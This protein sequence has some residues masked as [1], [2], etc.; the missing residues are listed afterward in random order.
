[1]GAGEC[2]PDAFE[3]DLGNDVADDATAAEIREYELTLCPDDEDWFSADLSAG[4]RLVARATPAGAAENIRLTILGP[5]GG[6][7]ADGEVFGQTVAAAVDVAAPGRHLVRLW[8]PFDDYAGPVRLQVDVLAA[9]AA[10][11][12]ACGHAVPLEPNQE[13]AFSQTLPVPRFVVSCGDARATQHLASF[14]LAEPT[15]VSLRVTGGRALAVRSGCDDPASEQACSAGFDPALAGVELGV[16]LYYV[17]VGADAADSP[18]VLLTTGDAGC[19]ADAACG[20]GN[21]CVGGVCRPVCLDDASC[22]GVQLCDQGVC[23]EPCMAHAD[24]RA[25]GIC[26]LE[27]GRCLGGGV[28][29]PDALEAGLGNDDGDHATDAEIREYELT[30]CAG[31]EDWFAAE[32]SA[33]SRLAIRATP[34]RAADDVRVEILGPDGAVLVEGAVNG[35]SV[36]AET[37]VA[38]PGRHLVRLWSPLAD[39]SGA[40]RLQV[41]ARAADTAAALACSHPVPLEPDEEATFSPTLPVQRFQLSCG[42]FQATNHLASFELAEPTQVWLHVADGSALAVRSACAAAASEEAC[43]AG[44][45]PTLAGVELGAGTYYVVVGAAADA[46]PEVVLTLGAPGCVADVGCEAGEVCIDG[47]CRPACLDDA[48]CP[49]L[50]VCDAGRC[51]DWCLIDGDCGVGATCI[52]DTGHCQGGECLPDAFEGE[53]GNDSAD[54]ATVAEIREYPL[55][56]CAGDEDWFSAELSAGSRLVAR[57]TPEGP[58]D[59]VELTILGPDDEVLVEG[60]VLGQTVEAQVDAAGPGRHLLRLWSPLADHGGGVRLQ[61]DALAADAAEALGCDHAVPL[62]QDQAVAFPRALPVQRFAVSC[63]DAQATQYLASFELGEPRR[64]TLQVTD[65]DAL[66]VRSACGDPASERACRVVPD[67]SLSD[68]DLGAGTFYVVLGATAA[69]APE[70]LLTTGPPGCAADAECGADHACVAGVCRPTCG[71]DGDCADAQ[72]CD[73]GACHAPC[74]ADFDCVAG[75]TCDVPSG[76][77][78]EPDACLADEDCLGV[79]VC[80]AGLCHEPCAVDAECAGAQTCDAASGHC[81]EPD[82]CGGDVDCLGARV[83]SDGTCPASNL[84]AVGYAVPVEVELRGSGVQRVLQGEVRPVGGA[85]RQ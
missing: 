42:D 83:C 54:D 56:L 57:A 26:E 60:E 22:P 40:V 25:G 7:V 64:V 65:G 21:V 70:I 35:Q 30:L 9:D 68:I 19:V 17:V 58:A 33:G 78:E 29:L 34:A 43:S 51:H 74:L 61:V 41:D 15:Q 62:E 5:G 24:C 2:L 36:E 20:D 8:S 27:S 6:V 84:R 76:H 1:V 85:A 69:A 13:V 46:A 75:Q 82:V 48:G 50:Q 77:C 28:C 4:S 44:A 12:L 32:L 11:A 37:D 52:A 47:A 81:L 63:G 59:D 14:E 66:A 23:H 49:D 80:D 18:Q 38:V 16:G 53:L 73:G 31:D 55:T 10:E 45:D 39:Y 67:P 79:R 72:V 71:D 3:A